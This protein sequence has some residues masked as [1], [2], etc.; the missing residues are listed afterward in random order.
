MVHDPWRLVVEEETALLQDAAEQAGWDL[1]D[2]VLE[3]PP[4]GMG[5]IAFPCFALA[6]RL[7][8]APAAIAR[9]LAA[10]I[11]RGALVVRHEAAGGYV[12]AHLD[13]AAF[14]RQVL[15]ALASRGEDYGRLPSTGTR[16]LLEHTSINPT[17]PIHV[18]RARNPILGDALARILRFAGFAVTTEFLVNDVGKQMVLLHWG[19]EHLS[20]EDVAPPERDKED[21]VLVRFYQKATELA[22][23]DAAV[24]AEVEDLIRRFEGGDAVLTKAIRRVAERM[25]RGMRSTLERIDVTY[26]SFFWESDLILHGRVP[27]VIER[28]KALPEAAEED[29]AC[30][31]D[32]A[33]H[34]VKGRDTRWFVTRRDG[35]SLYPTRDV[36]YHLDKFARCDVAINVLGEDQKLANAQLRIA[37]KLLRADKDVE[38]VFYGFVVLPKGR[39][40]TRK[41]RVVWMDDL[42]DEAVERAYA[43][44]R[45]RRTDLSE[46]RMRR[47][48]E[49]VGIGALRFNI[50][51]VQAEKK[52]VFRWEEALNFE[53]NSAPFVQ[54]A[55]ARACGILDKADGWAEPDVSVLSH[56][57]E[58]LL[59]KRLARLPSTMDQCATMRRP[60]PL[61][62]Y[63]IDTAAA[64]NQFY[65]DCPVLA[66]DP[67]LR[68]ARLA[69][70]DGTRIVLRNALYG[71]GV[72]APAE[73]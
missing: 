7:R 27:P 73:M 53:G 72:R 57:S 67:P 25:L 63:A 36:A 50:V 8:K 39:M 21:H 68:D 61:A 13:M 31:V 38:P 14:G 56:P 3:T 37:L 62:A 42:I 46:E 16:I 69:L 60:H 19:V 33:P 66:S 48:A 47:I 32:M 55:H 59:L 54:Y 41:G 1:G 4:E 10:S 70:V 28:L 6:K 24:R 5:D 15:A 18:G 12:N 2:V 11:S 52:I 40:S 22:E 44:V 34:G 35:T 43:E 30:Y 20:P 49:V 45:K 64:F 26:D 71:L 29:G 58:V 51:R 65:R 9:T 17:G 23:A